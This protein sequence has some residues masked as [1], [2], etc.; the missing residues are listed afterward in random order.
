MKEIK[1]NEIPKYFKYQK[2]D[3]SKANKKSKH[4]HQ[5]EECWIQY[6]LKIGLANKPVKLVTSLESYCTICGKIG[7]RFKEDKSIVKDYRRAVNTST[8]RWY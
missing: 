1:E 4:K 6:N 8:R 2:S 5:Y 7:D 3:T